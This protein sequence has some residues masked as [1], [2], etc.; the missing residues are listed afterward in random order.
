MIASSNM[1]TSRILT[2]LFAWLA[3][4]A[5]SQIAYE[6]APVDWPQSLP[7]SEAHLT[8]DAPDLEALRAEDLE[9]D[10]HKEFGYRF[11]VEVPVSLDVVASG[12]RFTG[13]ANGQNV[14][15][16]QARVSAPGAV[17]MNFKFDAL[18]L[19]KGAKLL[20]WD[21]NQSAYLGAYDHRSNTDD[22]EFAVGLI[23]ASDV[24]IELQMPARSSHTAEVVLGEVVYG[25]R[26]VLSKWNQEAQA[27]EKALGGP[28]GNSGACNV[29]VNCPE[30]DEWQTE[31]RSVA[32]IVSGGFAA[33]TGAL[34]NNTQQDGTPYFLTANHCLGGEGGWVFYFNH[35]SATCSGNTG[36]TSNSLSGS[37][38]RASN[39][40]SDFA[41]LELDETPPANFNVQYAGWDRT[42]NPVP[43][44]CGIH[45]PSGD[46]KKICFEDNAISQ[47][48]WGGAQTWR[49]ANWDLGV[50]EPGSS[51]SPLF[52]Q[53]HR[54][55]GQ[56]YGGSAACS[57]SYDNNQPDYYGRFAISWDGTSASNRLKDWLDPSGSGTQV[58]D[59]W[60]EGTEVFA[61]DPAAN[62][63]QNIP[64]TLCDPSSFDPVFRIKN[65][66]TEALTSCSLLV[67]YN[68]VAQAPVYWTGSLA[69]GDI[70]DVTLPTFTPQDGNND[71]SVIVDAEGDENPMNNAGTATTLLTLGEAVLTIDILTDTYGYETY[72]ELR[73]PNGDVVLSGGNENVGPNGGGNTEA[74]ND[75]PGAY[76]N[77]TLYSFEYSV[78]DPGCYTFLIVDDYA[79]G[80]CC[81]YGEGSYTITDALGTVM[82]SGG[83]FGGEAEHLFGMAAANNIEEKTTWQSSLFPNPG[84]GNYTLTAD[85]EVK[86]VRVI[87]AVGRTV[88][89]DN[90]RWDK[91][92]QLNL[93]GLP[94][95]SYTV[96]LQSDYGWHYLQLIQR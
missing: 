14:Q 71:L 75:D 6:G 54:I 25:Y 16:T 19:P 67:T 15:V 7:H 83:E 70:Q 77:S 32:L 2:V 42:D 65:F 13:R 51:G 22:G 43:N 69:P 50:T 34:V 60:P 82:A 33:C 95:G 55:I 72:W 46:V 17:S 40:G 90:T 12:E 49:V 52:D 68:G 26:D 76:D 35:E 1:T 29:N 5:F 56:L 93:A 87:D 80:I 94:A 11:G 59:G 48:N 88:L 61:S 38:L 30:G 39:G 41:L 4:P 44:A 24:V 31:S 78:V 66:G 89:Q 28:F 37:E 63:F 79:D 27:W 91:R 47:Q 64:E 62:G 18:R 21:T 45:H 96:Q 74:A 86:L 84:N 9:N 92:T 10:L 23:Y 20:I 73:G 81:D 8:L 85:T 36:P 57:G 58:L 53:N 3:L